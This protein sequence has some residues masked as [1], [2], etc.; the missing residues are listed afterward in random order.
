[1]GMMRD[2]LE[3]LAA[4]ILQDRYTIEEVADLLG[5]S[6]VLIG[7]AARSGALPSTVGDRG[8]LTVRHEDMVGWLRRRPYASEPVIGRM[9]TYYA[10][11]KRSMS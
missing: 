3:R 5:L 1:M 11:S 10:D 2:R 4:L 6:T 9:G 7:R 8:V